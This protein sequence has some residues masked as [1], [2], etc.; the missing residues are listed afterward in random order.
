M[1]VS[2]RVSFVLTTCLAAA[3]LAG[4]CT[5]NKNTT[6]TAPTCTVSVG[7]PTTTT[8]G[9][10]GGT[11]TAT[12]TAASGCAWTSTSSGSFVTISQGAS[13]TGTGTVQFSVAVNTGADRIATLTIAGT[14]VAISQRAA[15]A[16]PAPTLSAPSAKSPA[17]GQAVDSARPTLVVNNATATGSIG[18]VTYRFEVSDRTSFPVDA[19]RTFTEDGVAQGTGGATSWVVN[20]DLGANQQWFWRA[21]ATDG[22]LT[23][24]FSDVATFTT[25]APC[26]YVLTPTSATVSGIGGTSTVAVTT[27]STCAWT[28]SSSDPSFVTITSGANGTGNGTIT[29]SVAVNNGTAQRSGAITLA[30]IGSNVQFTITQDVNCI[31]NPTPNGATFTNAAFAGQTFVVTTSLASCG[32]SVAPDSP[33]LAVTAGFNNTGQGTVTYSVL[34]NGTGAQ[35]IGNIIIT[36]FTGGS[37][38][39]VVT[40]Q[41]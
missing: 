9:P 29:F 37:G 14:A 32:W 12:V 24:A 13:G 1:I 21:R 7:Q 19:L 30:G 36:G 18:T 11:G 40:Q 27:G 31:Y 4:A 2:H 22:T 17:A 34:A 5:D 23:S 20:H 25:A 28:A 10:E 16:A 8:F 3:L 41:P 35:R 15:P 6:P 39:F 38:S 33:W 26:A